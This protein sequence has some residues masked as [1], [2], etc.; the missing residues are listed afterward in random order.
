MA[1]N[2]A[3]LLPLLFHVLLNHASVLHS[4]HKV[5]A[6]NGYS[7]LDEL[8]QYTHN[9]FALATQSVLDILLCMETARTQKAVPEKY[10][11]YVAPEAAAKD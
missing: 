2:S 7:T 8:L 10:Q 5:N 6:C 3:L 1:N 9:D 11:P 4:P